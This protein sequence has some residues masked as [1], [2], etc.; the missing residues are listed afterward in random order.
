MSYTILST[1]ASAKTINVSF[2]AAL[3]PVTLSIPY[4]F[5]LDPVT[6]NAQNIQFRNFVNGF[7]PNPSFVTAE[8]ARLRSLSKSRTPVKIYVPQYLQS[9]S[10]L[11][12]QLNVQVGLNRIILLT[13]QDRNQADYVMLNDWAQDLQVHQTMAAANSDNYIYLRNRFIF[14][15]H[16]NNIANHILPW[17][18]SQ[19]EVNVSKVDI[20][21]INFIVPKSRTE[22]ENFLDNNR[23][24][25][26]TP[27]LSKVSFDT[28][29]LSPDEVLNLFTDQMYAQNST[30]R[31][32]YSMK[33][34]NQCY[35]V[36]ERY[37]WTD[38]QTNGQ[39]S[40]PIGSD[41]DPGYQGSGVLVSLDNYAEEDREVFDTLTWI[42]QYTF[43]YFAAPVKLRYKK[44]TV[45]GR[46]SVSIS[47][48]DPAINLENPTIDII[49]CN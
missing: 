35:I 1:N 23:R 14:L 12:Q 13:E 10:L 15:T 27:S 22:L 31:N 44:T 43:F 48:I 20:I 32:L 49:Y 37:D 9:N 33:E 25:L 36:E 7:A 38:V 42:L 8:V 19:G 45:N 11:M 41:S 6:V 17:K 29:Y 24:Y 30:S 40:S 3:N 26:V 2:N 5:W 47:E 28:M 39:I 34:V 18:A 46:I 4:E 16:V 21:P